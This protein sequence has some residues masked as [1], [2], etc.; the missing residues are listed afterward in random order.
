MYGLRKLTAPV[1]A[2]LC[3]MVFGQVSYS[4]QPKP[5]QP[6][7]GKEGKARPPIEEEVV[8]KPK[9][10]GI[11]KGG[12]KGA[13][14]EYGFAWS[15]NGKAMVKGKAKKFLCSLFHEL[16][17]LTVQTMDGNQV[18]A[19]A[20]HFDLDGFEFEVIKTK[21]DRYVWYIPNYPTP[22]KKGTCKNS[23]VPPEFIDG[24]KDGTLWA[25]RADSATWEQVQEVVMQMNECP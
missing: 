22:C 8:V 15:Q 9:G 25:R 4:Q 1:A 3:L 12:E 7:T 13:L 17:N 14:I 10:G 11:E 16:D 19:D 20:V 23:G 24:A 6:K 2:L 5:S 21:N 18:P